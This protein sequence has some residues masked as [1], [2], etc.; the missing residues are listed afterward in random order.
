MKKYLSLVLVLILFT[1]TGFAKKKERLLICGCNWNKIAQIDKA[2]GRILWSHPV[3]PGE[4]CNDIERTK[5]GAILYAYQ[6]GAR[7]IRE[8]H[9]VVWDYK[10]PEKAEVYTATELPDGRFMITMCG[11]PA[12]IV[13]LNKQGEVVKTIPFDPGISNIHDQFRQI[14]LSR[15]NTFLIPL[16]GSGEIAEIDQNGQIFRKVKVGG[17]LFSVH[18][19]KNGNWLVGCGD[20]H[21]FIEIEARSGKILREVNS[22]MLKDVDLLFVAETIRLK[23]GN[24]LVC[25]WCGHSANK[26]QAKVLEVSPDNQVVW[27]LQNPEIDNVSAIWVDR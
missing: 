6:K 2:S 27:Q 24:T 8:N 22:S 10:A 26:T 17:N 25:N 4:D 15:N 9:K 12:Q 13:F 19:L 18:E 20:A 3:L 21:R 16:M 14:V 1:G 11:S 5:Q 7:L 23:N